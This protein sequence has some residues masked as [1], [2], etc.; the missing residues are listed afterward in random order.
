[1]RDRYRDKRR[2]RKRYSDET[3][4][5]TSVHELISIYKL[6][7]QKKLFLS[8]GHPLEKKLPVVKADKEWLILTPSAERMF[9]RMPGGFPGT[10]LR[11][12]KAD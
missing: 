6:S 9:A 2:T 4:F 12:K 5:H 8:G 10:M 11:A 1:M 7:N 3:Y